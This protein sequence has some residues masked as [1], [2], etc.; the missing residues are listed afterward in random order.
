MRPPATSMNAINKAMRRFR[1]DRRASAAVE[2]AF[3]APIF[4]VLLFAIMETALVFFAA[5]ILE[6]GTQ[7]SARLMLTHQAQDAGMTQAQF[8]QDLCN[9]VSVMFTCS[10]VYVD[11]KSYAEGTTVN[12][13]DP[14]DASGNFVNNFTY[15]TTPAGSSATVVVRSFYQWPMFVTGL[16]YNIANIGRNTSNSK[17]LLAATS[18]FRV[19]P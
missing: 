9:R 15:Q 10:D 14:I 13:S 1:R 5:Q 16:G 4:F 19:E 11:V 17:R 8:K 6:T 7:D 2:F 18:A 12:I 3:V